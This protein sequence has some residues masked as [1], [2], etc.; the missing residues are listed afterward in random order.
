VLVVGGTEDALFPSA[1]LDEVA[2]LFPQGRT[3]LFKGAGHAAY[4]ERA[5]R[6]N[7]LMLDFLRHGH[8][9]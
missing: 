7:D 9:D 5:R 2:R 6:F 4:F 3:R 8:V 1:E